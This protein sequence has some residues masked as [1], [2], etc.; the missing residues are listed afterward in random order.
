M[1]PIYLEMH[2]FGPYAGKQVIDFRTLETRNLFLIYGPTG[3]GKT[4]VLDAICYALYG[5][6]SGAVNMLLLKSQRRFVL[7]SP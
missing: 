4:T 6:T 1:K 2:A 3:A 5:D 7:F